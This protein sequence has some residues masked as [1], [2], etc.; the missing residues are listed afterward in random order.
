[1][2]SGSLLL[3]VFLLLFTSCFGGNP[4]PIFDGTIPDP[5]P[6][7][8]DITFR[9]P[10]LVR[11]QEALITASTSGYPT[12]S[13]TW[14]FGA[15]LNPSTASGSYFY[16]TAAAMP[17]TYHGSVTVTN[18]HGTKTKEFDYVVLAQLP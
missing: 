12:P 13:V 14:D 15:G 7:P 4:F 9:L 1:M 3:P 5:M 6:G 2:R 11:N 18:E 10:T 17:G 16:V 8:P